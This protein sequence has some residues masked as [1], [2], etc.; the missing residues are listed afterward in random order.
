M[1]QLQWRRQ[2]N[3]GHRAFYRTTGLTSKFN[4][5]IKRKVWKLFDTE[6]EE[7]NAAHKP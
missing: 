1:K 4:V 2:T 5:L 6:T 7:T 3:L